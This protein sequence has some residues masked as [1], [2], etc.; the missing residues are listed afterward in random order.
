M[1]KVW[2]RDLARNEDRVV[3]AAVRIPTG[4]PGT[5]VPA[6]PLGLNP[7]NRTALLLDLA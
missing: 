7:I 3:N 1:K 2:S 6:S 4:H 5:H